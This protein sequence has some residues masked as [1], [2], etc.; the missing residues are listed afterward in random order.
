VERPAAGLDMPIITLETLVQAP[1]ERVFDLFRSVDDHVAS[2]GKSREVAV[3]G[4]TAGLMELGDTVTWEATHLG[5][6]QRLTSEITRFDRPRYF[7]DSMVRGA[8]RRFDHDH[9]FVPQG[10]AT[11]VRDVFDFDSPLGPLGRLANALFLTRYMRRFLE[12]RALAIK[13]IAE[14]ERA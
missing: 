3:A 4:K 6:R 5:V 1:I 8:F 7:R 10:E 11:L 13:R 2:T 9:F 12:E 14:G